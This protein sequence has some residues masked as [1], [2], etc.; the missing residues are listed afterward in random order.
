MLHD[1]TPIDAGP[2]R[3]E[4]AARAASAPGR[5]AE[6]RVPCELLVMLSRPGAD[7]V[8]G[9]P[10]A[11]R[12]IDTSTGGCGLV[13]PCQL[14]VGETLRMEVRFGLTTTRRLCGEVRHCRALP[15]GSFAAGVRLIAAPEDPAL[16]AWLGA[17]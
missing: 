8:A 15:N 13:T 5:R 10:W 17:R 1:S 12:I 16:R 6:E 2:S 14:N 4:A 9:E 11:A 7:G 3:S